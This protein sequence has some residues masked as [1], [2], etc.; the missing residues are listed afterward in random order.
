MANLIRFDINH[1]GVS[2]ELSADANQRTL[3]YTFVYDAPMMNSE[4]VLN[5]Q[6]IPSI[7]DRYPWNQSLY[8]EGVSAQQGE[9]GL[10]WEITVTYTPD[11]SIVEEGKAYNIQRRSII[12]EVVT[13]TAFGKAKFVGS[14]GGALAGDPEVSDVDDI[15]ITNSAGDPVVGLTKVENNL[16][17]EWWQLAPSSLENNI[18]DGSLFDYI[19]TTNSDKINVLGT[20]YEPWQIILRDLQADTYFYRNPDSL[21][22]QKRYKLSFTIEIQQGFY[23]IKILDQG[24]S[25]LLAKDPTALV[26]VEVKRAVLESDVDPAIKFGSADNKEVRQDVKLDGEGRLLATG[27]PPVYF[28]YQTN[29][30]ADFSAL[31]IATRRG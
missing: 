14:A 31:S 16:L 2:G 23:G 27:L 21:Q 5:N 3:I 12:R 1:A 10:T 28:A 4:D 18:E 11:V 24:V 26:P 8:V 7:G 30:P 15:P 20:R 6:N 17:I 29:R 9:T 22:T 13:M 19:G 25:A